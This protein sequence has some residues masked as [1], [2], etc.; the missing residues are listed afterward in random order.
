MASP[1]VE[2]Q[3]EHSC[4]REPARHPREFLYEDLV[5]ATN[6]FRTEDKLGSGGSGSGS[7]SG[8]V[9]KGILMDGLP[10]AVKRVERVEYGKRK[11]DNLLHN[12]SLDTW[13]F[14][15]TDGLIGRFLPWKLRYKVAVDIA[16]ALVYLHHDCCPRILHLDIKPENILLDEKLGA[17]LSDFGL[18]K[19]M[20]KDESEVYTAMIRGTAGYMAPKWFLGNPI[21]DN[22]DIYSYGKVLLDLF[23]GQRYVCLDSDGN[24][25]YIKGGNSALELRTFHAFM[26][27]KLKQ[28]SLVDV[29]DKR[30][31]EDGKVDEKEANSLLHAALCCLEEDPKKRPRDMLQVLQMLEA[32]KLDRIG[33]MFERFAKEFR[34]ENAPQGSPSGEGLLV[35]IV[36]GAQNLEGKLHTNP[37]AQ[38]FFRE[39]VLK[40]KQVKKNK[41]PKWGEEFTFLLKEAPMYAAITVIVFSAPLIMA[42]VQSREI[43]GRVCISLFDVVEKKRTNEM[44]QLCYDEDPTKGKIHIELQWRTP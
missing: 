18:S 19:L 16:G 44:Y 10:V 34:I 17:V 40:T 14:H 43:L 11:W 38:I 39:E 6:N 2:S 12:G 41:D 32:S 24:D 9:F 15:T 3:N 22:C 13:I 1:H 25:I 36:H 4:T 5:M 26:R 28:K 33:A 37:Y 23:F 7:G 27:D 31:M 20:N 30:L 42:S 21:S 35:I 8:S 29:I